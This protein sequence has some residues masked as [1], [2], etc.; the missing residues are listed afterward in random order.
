M[1]I[2]GVRSGPVQ[3]YGAALV[4][5]PPLRPLRDQDSSAHTAR[6][7]NGRVFMS[8][9]RSVICGV[10]VITCCSL[11]YAVPITLKLR[12]GL[13]E[14]TTEGQTSGSPPI[15]PEVLANM[16][17]DRRAKMEAVIAARRARAG[18]PHVSRQCITAE[19]LQKGLDLDERRGSDCQE[20]VVSSSSSEMNIQIQCKGPRLATVGN[21]HFTTSGSEQLTGTINMNVGDGEQNM[22]V[23]RVIQGKWIATDCG[24]LKPRH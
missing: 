2:V 3:G 18:Q 24:D 14:M 9:S 4:H 5:L 12:P 10:A 22:T 16:P 19:S 13:W 23:K 20:K 8:I 7:L 21:L 11:A 6:Q 17:P 15:P 1:T